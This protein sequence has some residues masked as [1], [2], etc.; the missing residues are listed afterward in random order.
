M[1]ENTKTEA[2]DLT[3]PNDDKLFNLAYWSKTISWVLLVIG[4]LRFILNIF[5]NYFAIYTGAT[6]DLSWVSSLVFSSLYSG[7][8]IAVYFFV[9]QAVGEILYLV[10]DI[11][12]RLLYQGD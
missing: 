3:L 12:E 7:F 11:K 6:D 2:E 8:S 9:L 1:E 5:S 4:I 10:I